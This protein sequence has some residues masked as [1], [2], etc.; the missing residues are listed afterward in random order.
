MCCDNPLCLLLHEQMPF[1]LLLLRVHSLEKTMVLAIC[2][3]PGELSVWFAAGDEDR[4]S[5][6]RHGGG[7]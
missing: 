4:P 3:Y 7:Q 2:S 5:E 6:T 1:C